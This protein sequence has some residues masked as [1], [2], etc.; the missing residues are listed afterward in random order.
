M[1]VQYSDNPE[2]QAAIERL[3]AICP[4]H[5][6]DGHAVTDWDCGDCGR[7][8][9]AAGAHILAAISRAKA[10]LGLDDEL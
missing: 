7:R 2:V 8:Q 3:V 4:V 5:V 1:S 9:D 6:V 10:A